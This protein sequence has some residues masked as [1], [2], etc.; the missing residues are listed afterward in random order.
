MSQSNR[1]LNLK[2]QTLV[3][4]ALILPI[5]MLILLGIFEFSRVLGAWMSLTHASREGAR[6]A[7]LGGTD[8]QVEERIDAVSA[9]LDLSRIQVTVT[10]AAPRNRGAMVTVQVDYSMDL[11]T[12]I[13]GNIVGNPL[14]IST[15]TTMRVE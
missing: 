11:I 9:G 12:P 2:G 13:I 5:L 4:F 14:N 10:P 3:E 15:E 7:A 8:L 6:D 1:F